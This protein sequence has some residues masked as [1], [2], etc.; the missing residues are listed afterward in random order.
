MIKMILLCKCLKYLLVITWKN[1]TTYS[2]L[3]SSASD[4]SGVHVY[5]YYLLK[6]I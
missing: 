4:G 2:R 3:C 6:S 5:Y 1:S